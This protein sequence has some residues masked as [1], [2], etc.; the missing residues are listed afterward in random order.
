MNE[1]DVKE[2]TV[3]DNIDDAERKF[4]S[5]KKGHP[6]LLF[7]F[8]LMAMFS[9]FAFLSMMH[10]GWGLFHNVNF[11]E[12]AIKQNEAGLSV[13][14]VGHRW[15]GLGDIYIYPRHMDIKYGN[16]STVRYNDGGIPITFSDG[17]SAKIN[18]IIRIDLPTST[19]DRIALHK[20][21]TN[22]YKR[23]SIKKEVRRVVFIAC[24]KVARKMTA[25][26]GFSSRR[27]EL[28]NTIQTEIPKVMKES[29]LLTPL[30]RYIN[31][32]GI[33]LTSIRYSA[34]F[35]ANLEKRNIAKNVLLKARY[36]AETAKLIAEQNIWQ[37]E[38]E[39]ANS[40]E[41]GEAIQTKFRAIVAAR[42]AKAERIAL[43]IENRGR[44]KIDP[45]FPDN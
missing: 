3:W 13:M 8:L 10:D 35:S 39:D 12:Y 27:A 1:K 37:K 41:E 22:L 9:V 43:L 14:E 2:K 45:N 28:F 40:I 5:S 15:K 11:D 38:Y 20:E 26:E 6:F 30:F 21:I 29:K 32:T 42:I 19:K 7:A 18:T 23:N 34:V 36:K 44:E 17:Y 4:I 16:S 31:I 25:D 33:I 24:R